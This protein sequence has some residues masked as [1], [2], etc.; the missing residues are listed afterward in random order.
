MWAS[1]QKSRIKFWL[2]A[3]LASV[4]GVLCL[5]TLV[6]RDWLEAFGFDPDRHTG[7]AEWAIVAA[8]FVLSVAC[9]T[10]AGTEWRRTAMAQ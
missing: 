6:W 3:A 4:T 9:A 2:E 7:R 1:D 10:A 5:V 8:L